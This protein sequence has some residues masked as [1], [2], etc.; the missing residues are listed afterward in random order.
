MPLPPATVRLSTA[1]WRRPRRKFGHRDGAIDR[2]VQRHRRVSPE[3]TSHPGSDRQ[4]SR[5]A[6]RT[7][8]DQLLSIAP[9]RRRRQRDATPISIAKAISTGPGSR[10]PRQASAL[11]VRLAAGSSGRREAAPSP[12]AK[13]RG[14]TPTWP[15]TRAASDRACHFTRRPDPEAS[16]PAAGRGGPR[17]RPSAPR[18]AAALPPE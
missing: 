3:S 4:R 14:R 15:R 13:C 2:R 17:P 7:H 10:L 6:S 18:P 1:R 5:S 12:R 16:G 9:A 8:P 11:S